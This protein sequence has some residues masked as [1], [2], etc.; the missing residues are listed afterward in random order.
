MSTGYTAYTLEAACWA[1]GTTD[2]FEEALVRAVNL[3]FD[4]DTVAAVTGQIAGALYG[5]SAI[6]ER[7]L[8]CLAQQ[9]LLEDT[10]QALI[11][12]SVDI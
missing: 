8:C 10:T 3:G 1:V 7:W 2:S 6:P 11:E 12:L 4:A 9:A 5:K